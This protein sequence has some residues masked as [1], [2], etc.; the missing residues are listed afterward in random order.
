MQ[1]W[2]CNHMMFAVA[3]VSGLQVPHIL[4]HEQHGYL[5]ILKAVDTQVRKHGTQP[6][7]PHQT[8][9]PKQGQKAATAPVMQRAFDEPNNNV[10]D[11]SDDE[12][13]HNK[14]ELTARNALLFTLQPL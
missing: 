3:A 13:A 7:Q 4:P 2:R 11:F 14:G 10:V 1:G 5:K 8:Q 9:R 12:Q 6:P